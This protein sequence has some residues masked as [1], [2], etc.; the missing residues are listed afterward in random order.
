MTTDSAHDLTV[1]RLAG[2]PRVD[3]RVLFRNP[4]PATRL[5]AGRGESRKRASACGRLQ[6]QDWCENYDVI[7]KPALVARHGSCVTPPHGR[8]PR[9]ELNFQA[10]RLPTEQLLELL[11]RQ[12]RLI[13]A[14]SHRSRCCLKQRLAQYEP[15]IRQEPTPT[16]P[17]PGSPLGLL[18]GLDAEERRRRSRR[19]APPE[20]PG[21]SAH[22]TQIRRGPVLRGTSIPTTCP[23]RTAAAARAC[24]LAA[25]RRW[26]RPFASAIA[27][28]AGP[29]A[30]SQPSPA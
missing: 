30:P 12:E 19:R 11:E 8:A 6:N 9:R 5:G 21:A 29:A 3:S 26:P 10:G 17:A 28:S 15:D 1:Q 25:R 2:F 27:F 13:P 4:C 20:I 22:A 14:P 7:G 16:E 18:Q 23:R 24:G